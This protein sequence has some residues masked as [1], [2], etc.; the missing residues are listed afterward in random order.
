MN[1]LRRWLEA[2]GFSLLARPGQDDC[3]VFEPCRAVFLDRAKPYQWRLAVLLHE[4][5][6][7]A[8]F[9]RRQRAAPRRRVAGASRRETEAGVG[10]CR[11][12]STA[13]KISTLEEEIAAWEWGQRLAARLR[14]R[15]SRAL[16]ERARA[17]CLMTYVRWG[18]GKKAGPPARG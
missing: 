16:F 13:C 2:R 9:R 5:G 8:I 15:Y 11:A 18:A 17:R 6:H 12:R 14:V 10:R 4:C 3:A 7:V 1:S